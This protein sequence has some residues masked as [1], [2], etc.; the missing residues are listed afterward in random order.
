EPVVPGKPTLRGPKENPFVLL[1]IATPD[2]NAGKAYY[3]RLLGWTFE[4]VVFGPSYAL[5][6]GGGLARGIGLVGGPIT[7]RVRG[8]TNYVRVDDLVR[9]A[10]R[11]RE[12]GGWIV[13]GPG[14]LPGEGRYFI[15]E[16]L[17][18]NRVGVLQPT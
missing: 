9:C 15:F 12:A 17:D 3:S 16:D 8:T 5:H 13:L 1:E 14:E 11:V 2:L 6:E 18:R 4:G 7:N 10:A